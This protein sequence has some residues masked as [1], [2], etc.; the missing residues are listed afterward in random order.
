[1]RIAL[2]ISFLLLSG[3]V[4]AQSITIKGR[5]SDGQGAPIPFATVYLKN[6]T[7]GTSANSEG[8]YALKLTTGKKEIIFRAVGYKLLEK[9][10]ELSTNLNLNITLE[11]EIYQ[12]KDVVVKAGG[13]D[14]A[15]AII[16]KAIKERKKHLKENDAYTAEVYIKG[17][18]KLLKAPKKFL[19]R[20]IDK[21]AKQA[22]LDSN[23]TGIVYLSESQSKLSYKAPE[24]KEEMLSSKVSDSNRAFSFNRAS[25][26][27]INFYE[28]LQNLGDL[29]NRPF[30]SPIADNAL[31][32]YD[33]KLLGSSFENGQEIN[34]IQLIPK[35]GYDP[36]FKG[37]IYIIENSWRIYSLD[38]L[39]TKES[40]I[41]IL[42]S[43]KIS[44]Q[45]Y[46]VNKNKWMPAS[47]KYEFTGGL[48]GFR[49]GG[50]FIALYS[51]YNLNP[52]FKEKEF[53]EVLKITK[54]VNQKD[55]S[56]WAQVRP[57]PLTVDEEK[58]Y[59][60]KDSLARKRESKPYLDSLDSVNNKFK[61]KSFL[62]VGGY[63]PRNRFKNES[64]NFNS[65][66]GSFSYNTVEG[67][68][69]N[70]E[71]AYRKK[72]D[73][74]NNRYLGVS[75]KLRYGFSNK[76]FNAS[77][78]G[79]IPVLTSA[80][81]ALGLGSDVVDLNNR[82]SVKPLY[83]SISS[84]FYERNLSK[85]YQK[86]F[87]NASLSGR[88]IGGLR[89][90]VYSE[91]ANKKWLPN[92]SSY[93]IIDKDNRDFTSNNPFMPLADV[94]LFPAYQSLKI[95][96]GLSYNF[97]N[98]YVSYP[99]GRYY[100]QTLYPT[101]ALNYTKGMKGVF[102]SDVDYDLIELSLSKNDVKTGFYGSF[103]FYIGAGKFINNRAVFYPDLKHFRGN[104]IRV[105]EETG[106][107]FMFLD[108]YTHSTSNQYIEG[109]FEH[110]FSGFF[111]NKIPLIRKLRLKELIGVN[112]LTTSTLQ[113]YHEL[114]VGLQYLNIK[115][116][117]GKSFIGN[118][119]SQ[120]GLR[121]A[122]GL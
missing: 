86:R 88:I 47:V 107:T 58:D 114:F 4:S 116:Y 79:N 23:R 57:V 46:T 78:K 1:M 34:K 20:D 83:N 67:F 95:G 42:D 33:Y 55:T 2:L 102:A 109:H 106:N 5:V 63:N 108:Y 52:N 24:Y 90:Q 13:E 51:N 28:N 76:L 65:L 122:I 9:S 37:Y 56:Y 64:Y 8:E 68:V 70:Y 54:E 6:S 98:K 101:L 99:S 17:L 115:A 110:N 14:P 3:L 74:L 82:G 77:M 84:L 121:L 61:W 44:Q 111:T 32:Y 29:S 30:I 16:R 73:T 12:L 93:T 94:P 10:L 72:I 22:G 11:S 41:K 87:V 48:L 43:L 59:Q 100:N 31:F 69:M 60:K 92:T 105:F 36:A 117:V 118:L 75:G 7:I 97:S 103:N 35:R 50:Y 91:W 119:E 19:G 39:M 120:S 81:L 112:Y 96:L 26:M 45:Y 104:Q 49:F 66:L 38:V 15:Y 85:F 113:N 21:L 71:A 40:N 53:K 89:G 80:T 25:D 62:L 27:N 18:Q